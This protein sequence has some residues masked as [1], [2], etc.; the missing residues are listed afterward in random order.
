[1]PTEILGQIIKDYYNSNIIFRSLEDEIFQQLT[2]NIANKRWLSI[3]F[4]CRH[5]RSVALAEGSLWT[6]I[7]F[8]WHT[9][10]VS[11]FIDRARHLPLSVRVDAD[12]VWIDNNKL[13]Y[14]DKIVENVQALE[15]GVG[16]RF[17][18]R[19]PLEDILYRPLPHLRWLTYIP[20]DNV[21][22][23]AFLGG[24]C[25]MLTTPE[26]S[27]VLLDTFTMDFF[28]EFLSLKTL[29]LQRPELR[30]GVQSWI[31]LLRNMPILGYRSLTFSGLSIPGLT[32]DSIESVSYR[33]DK[34]LLMPS[35]SKI[36]IK[37]DVLS[38][39]VCLRIL[40]EPASHLIV[41]LDDDHV[42]PDLAENI[43]EVFD[44]ISG[45]W[46]R[47]MGVDAPLLGDYIS[48]L[49]SY[50]AWGD[51]PHV[52]FSHIR[53]DDSIPAVYFQSAA[54]LSFISA[55]SFLTHIHTLR[56]RH[57]GSTEIFTSSAPDH[58]SGLRLIIVETK[59]FAIDGPNLR[60]WVLKRKG[61]ASPPIEIQFRGNDVFLWKR[62]FK[63]V[64]TSAAD[65]RID[66]GT[67]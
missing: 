53:N 50:P 66:F 15:F 9:R 45:F 10:L 37:C 28:P 36:C 16:V 11:T 64:I 29:V 3:T 8:E 23:K 57:L 55:F 27:N 62:A 40:P 67:Q 35:L 58:L 12:E 33:A 60:E 5:F 2:L 43:N 41:E 54:P 44:K 14:F 52:R 51:L 42:T 56:L 25:D 21:L 32:I 7:D 19:C 4:V 17:P 47:K 24:A 59:P 48:M 34:P 46:R 26:L 20:D 39:C 1:M 65:V 31:N 63:G 61:S 30:N 13:P 22:D 38:A 18:S 49:G 6:T